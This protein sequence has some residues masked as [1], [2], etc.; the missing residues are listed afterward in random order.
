MVVR[1]NIYEADESE[2][3]IQEAAMQ[4]GGTGR[5][6]KARDG[7]RRPKRMR[8]GR[9]GG[10]ARGSRHKDRSNK[11]AVDIGW[12]EGGKGGVRRGNEATS[13]SERTIQ[14]SES[15]KRV[16]NTWG[17]SIDVVVSNCSSFVV[18]VGKLN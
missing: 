12:E 3:P 4:P 2:A 1:A 11:E 14:G 7:S 8:R 10:V 5:G 15:Q 6:N 18:D 16:R 17:Y 13:K 9:Q